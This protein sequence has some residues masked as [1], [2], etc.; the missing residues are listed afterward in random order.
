MNLINFKLIWRNLVKN[1]GITTINVIGL[2]VSFAVST[3]II[4]FLQ[5][6]YS[7]DQSNP[8]SKDCYR[9]LTTFKYPNS[10]ETQTAMASS[11][12]GPHLSLVSPDVESYLRLVNENENFL[13]RAN[14]REATIGKNIQVDSTFFDFFNFPLLHGDKKTVFNKLE[15]IL[16]T[17][18]LSEKLFGTENPVGNTL[19]YTYSLNPE[20]DTTIQYIIAAVF[21]ALPANS[22]L[23]FESLMPLNP[24]QFDAIDENNRWHSI[25]TTT[26]LQLRNSTKPSAE[27]AALFPSYLDGKMQGHDMIGLDLQAFNQI[28]LDSKN[29]QYDYD[30]Y[31]KSDRSYL[32]VFGLIAL[33]ILLISS[34]N[35]ANLSTVLAMRRVR[36]VGVRKSLGA[37]KSDLLKQFLGEAILMSII[38]GGLALLWV[39]F[40]YQPFLNLLGRQIEFNFSPTMMITYA[41]AIILLGI[42]AGI[43]PAVQAAK[44]SAVEA[45]SKL[46]TSVSVKRPFIQRLVVLQFI[47]SAMLII[48]SLICYHQLDY[49]QNKDLG[50]EYDQM[51]ELYLGDNNWQK[52][53]AFKKELSQIAGVT[54]VTGSQ[55]SLGEIQGQRGLAVRNE[56]TKEIEN[57]PMTINIVDPNFFELYEMQFLEGQAPTAEG[58]ATGQEFVVNESFVKRVGWKENPL[59]KEIIMWEAGGNIAG[60]VVGVIKDIHHNT[61]HNPI[62][63]I[64]FRASN[65]FPLISLKVN[66]SNVNQVL[67]QVE[68]I[69]NQHIKDR[70][71]DYRF[72]DAHLAELYA[73]ENRLGQILLLATILSILIACLGLL[74]LSAFIIQQRAKEIGIRKVLGASTVGL[75]GL[76]SKDFLKLV[77]I[78]FLIATPF[79][80]YIMDTWLNN[81]AYRIDIQWWSFALAG[82]ASLTIAF[83]TVG[84][85]SLKAALGNPVDSIK[86]D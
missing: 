6:E 79:A 54:G 51:I 82:I 71:F 84:S 2:S 22:H 3:L 52:S 9:L 36:E 57:F 13:C 30:N 67:S 34:I 5:F 77:L 40:L 8:T 53:T 62:E 45:F 69:W 15:N 44:S 24:R 11:M 49:L 55:G 19:E 4:L 17:R 28:H 7:F 18:P 35:F 43:F 70:P 64:C 31:Q 75:I 86:N 23:Q 38:G 65:E 83:L 10:P 14:G 78:A 74:A 47:M 29:I 42:F 50:F 60:R 85:Q 1:A 80:W 26:Y 58:A 20:K 59:N 81:F 61:L 63:A 46:G 32:K 39:F 21:D 66:P 48:G 25:T 56:T 27:V 41:S 16:I 68:I 37:N 12:M 73:S 33:F 76:L 72:V